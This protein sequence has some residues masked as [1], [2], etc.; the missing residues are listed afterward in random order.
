MK[1]K[2]V[3]ILNPDLKPTTLNWE[4]EFD[5]KSYLDL[6]DRVSENDWEMFVINENGRVFMADEFFQS[7]DIKEFTA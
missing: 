1:Y 3:T 4:N 2:F 7:V 6:E 5:N